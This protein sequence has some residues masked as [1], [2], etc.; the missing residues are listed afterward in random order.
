MTT[1]RFPSPGTARL[2]CQ[3][4]SL[5][6]GDVLVRYIRITAM[7]IGKL[8]TRVVG[9]SPTTVGSGKPE[10]R[11]LSRDSQ[12]Q[13]NGGMVFRDVAVLSLP[14]GLWWITSA[15]S[16]ARHSL[17]DVSCRLET[18]VDF[19]DATFTVDGSADAAPMYLQ[20]THRFATAGTVRLRCR[21]DV[22]QY[23]T[24][25][26]LVA[27]RAGHLVNRQVGG[28]EY[29]YGS[30]SPLIISAF[31]DDGGTFGA[32]GQTLATLTL[33]A[34]SW[35]LS[36]KLYVT[37]DEYGSRVLCT[38]IAGQAVDQVSAA[39]E[40]GHSSIV[41][42]VGAH[43][44]GA[45]GGTLRLTCRSAPDYPIGSSPIQ[46]SWIKLTAIKLSGLTQRPL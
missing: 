6:T 1:H 12:V 40:E 19:D 5:Q 23:I 45:G 24:N 11:A 13:L 20:V 32:A 41:H 37:R 36:A 46:A 34:G 3:S 26:R 27:V 29:N 2:R 15:A 16:V 44:F 7:Q 31:R 25:S 17:G 18:P 30:G 4:S 28:A 42:L 35:M 39:P 33:P 22:D 38:L 43:T 9:G 10:V 14:A 8:T 21:G